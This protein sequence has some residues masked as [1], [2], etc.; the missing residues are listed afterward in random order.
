MVTSD[1]DFENF[2]GRC[3]NRLVNHCLVSITFFGIYFLVEKSTG[4]WNEL[5]F[6]SSPEFC[7]THLIIRM[8]Y[9]R[10]FE[11]EFLKFSSKLASV[12]QKQATVHGIMGYRLAYLKHLESTAILGHP[13]RSDID[14]ATSVNI[15]AFYRELIIVLKAVGIF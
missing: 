15:F 3:C 12:P 11:R 2:I 4:C 8:A 5:N 1:S 7:H 10:P 13:I 14:K 6:R 9:Y